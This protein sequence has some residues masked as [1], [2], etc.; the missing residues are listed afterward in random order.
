MESLWWP[1]QNTE[2]T[3]A[4]FLG[5]MDI[6]AQ[7]HSIV[8]SLA[9]YVASFP[10][11][12][13]SLWCYLFNKLYQSLLKHNTPTTWCYLPRTSQLGLV[14]SGFKLL[15][16]S[17][18]CNNHYD[19][20]VQFSLIR[21]CDTSPDVP[22]CVYWSDSFYDALGVKPSSWLSGLSAHAATVHVLLWCALINLGSIFTISFAFVLTLIHTFHIKT[23]SPSLAWC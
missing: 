19:Q 14:F 21:P 12:I 16:S 8:S 22:V 15:S 5:S 18:K 13:L 2:T 6:W 3:L 10:P 7:F 11:N 17:S 23:C 9:S 1:L 4:V 20:T